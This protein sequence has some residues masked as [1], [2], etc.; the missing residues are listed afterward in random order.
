MNGL[1]LVGFLTLVMILHW[2]IVQLED[3]LQARRAARRA[4]KPHASASSPLAGVAYGSPVRAVPPR[5]D[6]VNLQPSA[7]PTAYIPRHALP[8]R[9]HVRGRAS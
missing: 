4:P 6:R 5:P 3:A 1:T 7:A 9:V 2:L 8:P